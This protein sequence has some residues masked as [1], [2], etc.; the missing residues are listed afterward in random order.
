M[1]YQI[2]LINVFRNAYLLNIKENKYFIK[3]KQLNL[4]QNYFKSKF[5]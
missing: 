5:I 1:T 4:L 3:V 2:K